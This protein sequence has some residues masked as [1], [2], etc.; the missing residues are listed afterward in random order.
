MN[1]EYL[2]IV[3]RNCRNLKYLKM[4]EDDVTKKGLHW[5]FPTGDNITNEECVRNKCNVKSHGCPLL[6]T[7]I[8]DNTSDIGIKDKMKVK[9]LKY[10]KHLK[11]Y[12]CEVGTFDLE[13]VPDLVTQVENL[14]LFSEISD[15]IINLDADRLIDAFPNVKAVNLNILQKDLEFLDGFSKLEEVE[16]NLV[17]D[18]FVDYIG[19]SPLITAY[20]LF[21]SH[22]NVRNFH[23]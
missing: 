1:D 10:F 11:T 17:D 13:L 6:E 15:E 2:E 18:Y 14:E 22:P 20:H 21:S 19:M 12:S 8:L 4:D 9:L 7:L 3:G 16:L 5:I 23:E